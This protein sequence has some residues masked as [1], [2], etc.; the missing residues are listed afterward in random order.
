MSDKVDSESAFMGFG[1][2]IIFGVLMIMIVIFFTNLLEPSLDISQE[3]A[4][5][6]CKNLTNQSS[7]IGSVE[8][9]KLIC[10]TPSYDSTQ[11]III[12]SNGE[13]G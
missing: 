7:S 13:E 4:N 9:G 11:N 12:K 3:T 8:E 5:D 10:E 1:F 6:I 2:G